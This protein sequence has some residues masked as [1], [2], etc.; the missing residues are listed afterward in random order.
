[1]DDEAAVVI[2]ASRGA[3]GR[4]DM[5]ATVLPLF[6]LDT[7][8]FPGGVLPLR[9]FEARYMDMIRGA[10]R[11]GGAFG[12]VLIRKGREAGDFGVEIEDVGCR[13]R[14][15]SWDMAQLGVLEIAT[16]GTTRFRIV[17]HEVQ[18]DGLLVANVTDVDDE[19]PIDIP[20]NARR[21]ITLL[22][23][24]VH[25]MDAEGEALISIAKPYRFD[26]ATW[27]GNRI[28]EILPIPLPA[29]Q[30]LMAMTDASTRF[31]ILAELFDE[32]GLEEA[33]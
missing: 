24:I 5:T 26:D 2:R 33:T 16:T 25:R 19:A 28:A 9:V 12:V 17:D 15:D 32:Y 31:A 18:S 11:G 23:R 29:K 21:G 27:V 14:I 4:P 8:L 7:V 6:P 22:E 20:N 10:M 13:A 3:G 30:R 1:V